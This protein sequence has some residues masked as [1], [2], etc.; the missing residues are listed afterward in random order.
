[1]E[2]INKLHK[3]FLLLFVM[4]NT[5]AYFS[6]RWKIIN[7][8]KVFFNTK[9]DR[10]SIKINLSD[11]REKEVTE[12]L[13]LLSKLLY[14]KTIYSYDQQKNEI[15][16][17]AFGKKT[18]LKFDIFLVGN[19]VYTA[20]SAGF[21]VEEYNKEFFLVTIINNQKFIIRKKIKQD[22]NILKYTFIHD[23]Y[24]KYL[25]DIKD[26][27][28]LDIGGY[29]GD[30]AIY[31]SNSGASV[32][33]VYEPHPVLYQML[34]KNVALNNLKN[35]KTVNYGISDKESI[36]T[37]KEDESLDGPTATFGLTTSGMNEG[38]EVAV[39]VTSLG[40]VIEDIGQID[41]MKMDCEGCEFPAILSCD[42]LHLRKI[43]K[44][45]LE[46]HCNAEKIIKH[47]EDSGFLVEIEN[48]FLIATIR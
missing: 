24:G 35:I 21:F 45:V 28:I 44:M 25:P 33:Y 13:Y 16:F 3:L 10:L 18:V 2:I 7:S 31:F 38:K 30:T 1:M 47:L 20:L 26:M 40:A 41:F 5:C 34:V 23:E 17:S 29:I 4:K 11:I 9:P 8:A 6:V 48:D 19:I 42:K 36:I 37:I 43:K 39:K 46:I 22:L 15:G 12:C 14:N 27:V 32:V